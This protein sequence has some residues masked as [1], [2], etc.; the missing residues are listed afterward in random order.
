MSSV[1]PDFE[2]LA[3]SKQF[4]RENWEKGTTCPCCKQV[5]KQYKRKMHSAMGVML[6]Q[7]YKLSNETGDWVHV[8]DL[9]RKGNKV[10]TSAD[11]AYLRY[12]KLLEKKPE[13]EDQDKKSNGYWR[14]TQ[15]GKE[16][17]MGSRKEL[18][19]ILLYN[20]GFYGLSGELVDIEDV[21]GDKFSYKE[22]MGIK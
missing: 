2:T 4:L 11:Y 16:F 3:E 18:S 7:F 8:S 21:L 1:V 9:Y 10:T 20:G 6:I 15:R 13:D 14:I 19:H 17:A 12:W 5:V 22:L